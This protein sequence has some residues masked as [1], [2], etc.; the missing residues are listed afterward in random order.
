MI[1]FPNSGELSTPGGRWSGSSSSCQ[2]RTVAHVRLIQGNLWLHVELD[3]RVPFLD[4]Q[5]DF[6]R[7]PEQECRLGRDLEELEAHVCRDDELDRRPAKGDDRPVNPS[8]PSSSVDERS[9]GPPRKGRMRSC[10]RT[11]ELG[12]G[13]CATRNS[14]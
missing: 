12:S 1:P 8:G 11:S 5:R 9:S 13:V 4:A 10:G 7:Y 6:L 3:D 14:S 2:L